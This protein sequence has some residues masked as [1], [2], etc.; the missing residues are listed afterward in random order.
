M[1]EDCG[2]EIKIEV[3]EVRVVSVAVKIG[4]LFLLLDG[5]FLQR[6]WEKISFVKLTDL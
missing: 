6:I 4:C 5:L 3:F 2:G 1:L